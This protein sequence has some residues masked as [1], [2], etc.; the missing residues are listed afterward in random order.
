MCTLFGMAPP[1]WAGR[2]VAGAPELDQK[3][4]I[5]GGVRRQTFWD[6][7][8]LKIREVLAHLAVMLCGLRMMAQA[9]IGDGLSLDPFAFEEDGL[10]VSEVDFGRDEIV[11]A[12]VIA[13]SPPLSPVS[14]H[15]RI[16]LPNGSKTSIEFLSGSTRDGQS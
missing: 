15:K 7:L 8:W 6:T 14:P 3:P 1:A 4:G 12:F 16:L 9:A 10:T 11:E 2:R 5:V 13:P